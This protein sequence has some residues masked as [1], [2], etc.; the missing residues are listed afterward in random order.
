MLDMF[1]KKIYRYFL[2]SSL[3]KYFCLKS[4][5][6][7]I[8]RYRV[9][10]LIFMKL[11]ITLLINISFYSQIKCYIS[12]KTLP[13]SFSHANVTYTDTYYIANGF[14][15]FFI[16]IPKLLLNPLQHLTLLTIISTHFKFK[17][18]SLVLREK[19][20]IL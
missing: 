2:F 16:N 5:I 17:I 12:L 19:M 10:A 6:V 20:K 1:N 4:E 9:K 3:R 13:D 15:N 11:T 7:S 8:M 14:N 18:M